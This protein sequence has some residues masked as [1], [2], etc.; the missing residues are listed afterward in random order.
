LV[1][2][3]EIDWRTPHHDVLVE[4]LNSW[5]KWKETIYT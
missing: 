4:F 3:L 2:L 1:G 5:Q